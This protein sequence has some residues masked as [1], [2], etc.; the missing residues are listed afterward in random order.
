MS[1]EAHTRRVSAGKTFLHPSDL[2]IE[3]DTSE[4]EVSI[5]LPKIST[6]FEFHS[7]LGGFLHSGVRIIDKSKNASNNNI[8]VETMDEDSIGGVKKVWINKDGGG[9]IT[10]VMGTNDWFFWVNSEFLSESFELKA[11]S[12]VLVPIEILQPLNP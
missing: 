7:R 6:L 2:F 9:M 10:N 1:I 4:G 5:V 12:E 8:I 3:C 11:S